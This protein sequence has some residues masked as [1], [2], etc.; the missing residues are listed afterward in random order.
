MIAASVWIASSIA[1]PLGA[2]ISRLRALTMPAVT[3]CSS[4]KGLPIATTVSPTSIEPE[5]A[6]S[7]GWSSEA[8]A[9]TSSTARSVDGSVPT[10]VASYVFPFQKVTWAVSAPSTTCWFV[11]T[12]PA[13]S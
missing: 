9:S 3:V 1:K 11:S 4:P 13:S 6:S 5:S 8:G 2:L 7:I 12:W 10:T